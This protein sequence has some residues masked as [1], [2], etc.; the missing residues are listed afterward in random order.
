MQSQHSKVYC[1]GTVSSS[2]MFCVLMAEVYT[3]IQGKQ[4]WNGGWN[5]NGVSL[6][7]AL[8]KAMNFKL[9]GWLEV[10]LCTLQYHSRVCLKWCR[11]HLFSIVSVWLFWSASNLHY[12]VLTCPNKPDFDSSEMNEASVKVPF[13][14]RNLKEFQDS[15]LL[16]ICNGRIHW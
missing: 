10:I 9:L 13:K 6:Y 15:D 8:N 1:E 14:T 16:V 4:K 11:D 5:V 12:C 3:R 7:K 2:Q